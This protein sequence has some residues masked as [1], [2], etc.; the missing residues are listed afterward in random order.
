MYDVYRDQ[1]ALFNVDKTKDK[2]QLRR[3]SDAKSVRFD[4]PQ[5][6]VFRLDL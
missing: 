6:N 4:D 1:I 3:A 5:S 2:H